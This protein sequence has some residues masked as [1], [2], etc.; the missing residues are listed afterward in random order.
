L[1]EL[2]LKELSVALPGHV[3]LEAAC[4]NALP[5][6]LGQLGKPVCGGSK[7]ITQHSTPGDHFVLDRLFDQFVL[8]DAK[9]RG[10]LGG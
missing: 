5:L 6:L 3:V 7:I 8:A 10:D 9:P 1:D 4:L 2:G